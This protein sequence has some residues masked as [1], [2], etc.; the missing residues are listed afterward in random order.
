MSFF[1]RVRLHIEKNYSTC[2]G[3]VLKITVWAGSDP[4]HHNASFA[5]APETSAVAQVT[6]CA[7]VFSGAADIRPAYRKTFVALAA[8]ASVPQAVIF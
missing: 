1:R 2:C 4:Y 7:S 8:T 6:Y 3:V 5:A